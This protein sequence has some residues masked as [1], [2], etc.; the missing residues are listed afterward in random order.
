MPN[1]NTASRQPMD[2]HINKP[3]NNS[4]YNAVYHASNNYSSAPRMGSHNVSTKYFNNSPYDE[5]DYVNCRLLPRDLFDCPPTEEVSL[6]NLE[7]ERNS[8][9]KYLTNQMDKQYRHATANDNV[10][11][12]P[13]RVSYPFT[14][15][16]TAFCRNTLEPLG[17][18]VRNSCR[19]NHWH[20]LKYPLRP[21]SCVDF[22]QGSEVTSISKHKRD[23][24]TSFD[25]LRFDPLS[26]YDDCRECIL[27]YPESY[28]L[29]EYIEPPSYSHHTAIRDV[30]MYR[31]TGHEMS[32]PP[33]IL[34]NTDNYQDTSCYR[35]TD[36]FSSN[37]ESHLKDHES[38]AT[39]ETLDKY[40]R[41]NARMAVRPSTH[42]RLSPPPVMGPHDAGKTVIPLS[43]ESS[44][45]PVPSPRISRELGHGYSESPQ[46]PRGD[47]PPYHGPHE[48]VEP[49]SVMVRTDLNRNHLNVSSIPNVPN[50]RIYGNIDNASSVNTVSEVAKVPC[51]SAP[52]PNKTNHSN[53]R[54]TYKKNAVNLVRRASSG[55]SLLKRK[56]A[57][58]RSSFHTEVDLDETPSLLARLRREWQDRGSK[59]TGNIPNT[60]D[61]KLSEKAYN[62]KLSSN[63]HSKSSENL[64]VE[65]ANIAQK[66]LDER[67]TITENQAMDTK[68]TLTRQQHVHCNNNPSSPFFTNK[69]YNIV[70][71]E[72]FN[73][74]PTTDMVNSQ[75][76]MIVPLTPN[77]EPKIGTFDQVNPQAEPSVTYQ[78]VEQAANPSA[79]TSVNMENMMSTSSAEVPQRYYEVDISDNDSTYDT[80]IIKD[81]SDVLNDSRSTTENNCTT[82]VE[83]CTHHHVNSGACSVS[84]AEQNASG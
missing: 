60:S 46:L 66:F 47:P 18:G 63:I 30:D 44:K 34:R 77:L 83:S 81:V 61:G 75:Q 57:K 1:T 9:S 48:I 58:L 74:L 7:N 56:S 51:S 4:D 28:R 11:Y 64:G 55:A 10:F 32:A 23:K 43:F 65:M 53:S 78:T 26:G 15:S 2:N 70:I 27:K 41:A 68:S 71:K 3:P 42:M 13:G 37:N 49:T 67:W 72:P 36:H 5:P 54:S 62:S 6:P 14:E 80:L 45:T 8:Y 35:R 20:P 50:N 79:A 59:S 25:H 40:T 24:M 19:Y 52:E 82:C 16:N 33:V 39:Y 22:T 76:S 12:H 73:N 69:Q 31:Y 29:P 17:F 38:S 84:T 21:H